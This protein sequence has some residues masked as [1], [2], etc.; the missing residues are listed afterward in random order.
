[1]RE[2]EEERQAVI[3]SWVAWFNELG[4]AVADPGNPFSGMA[5]TVSSDGSISDGSMGSTMNGYSVVKADSLDEATKMAQGCPVLKD[6]STVT[7]YET[8]QVM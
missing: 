8:F 2:T 1:M 7:V 6:G 4:S 5:K 3:Q